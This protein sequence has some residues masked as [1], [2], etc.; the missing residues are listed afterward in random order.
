[1]SDI[2]FCMCEKVGA[3]A[4]DGKATCRQCGGVDAYKK[5]PL[6]NN[7]LPVFKRKA[8][9]QIE[10]LTQENAALQA[11]IDEVSAYNYELQFQNNL[12]ES[13]IAELEN[14]WISINDRLPKIGECVLVKCSGRSNPVVG[15]MRKGRDKHYFST[16]AW[17]IHMVH[18]THWQP[19]PPTPEV[20]SHETCEHGKG[21]T[22]YCQP[23]GRIH[24]GG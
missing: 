1:M 13:R 2:N 18:V 16:I 15:I 5:S 7:E 12:F 4:R 23:C 17:N 10:K 3:V 11:K 9:E 20:K 8:D 14:P 21:L 6:R 24:G 19:L 22:D